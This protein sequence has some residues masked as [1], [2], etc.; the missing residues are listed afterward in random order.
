[1]KKRINF[2]VNISKGFRVFM[3]LSSL[4]FLFN[5]CITYK[6]LPENVSEKSKIS[7]LYI[8]DSYDKE[9]TRIWQLLDYKHEI[10]KDSMI[11]KID[12]LDKKKLSFTFIKDNEVIGKKIIKGKFKEDNCFYKRRFFYIIPIAPILWGFENNQTR[13][14]LFNNELVIEK[15]YN[16][17]GVFIFMA[18]GDKGNYVHR[19]KR[20]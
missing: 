2:I 6:D 11:V 5:S 18:S 1:M 4:A 20:I 13:I 19:F 8:N 3:L 9:D 14:Y 16:Y 12:I 17:G 15:A 7:G 10:K